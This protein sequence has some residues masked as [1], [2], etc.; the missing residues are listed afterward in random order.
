[1]SNAPPPS[2]TQDLYSTANPLPPEFSRIYNS[3]SLD[4]HPPTF[5]ILQLN[6]H[7]RKNTTLSVVSSESL[8]LAMLLQE[9]WTNLV[10]HLPPT[11]PGWHRV[12]LVDRPGNS[13]ERQQ[14]CIYI[15][16][17]TPTYNFHRLLGSSK[18]LTAVS[19]SICTEHS[20]PQV[21]FLISLYNPPSSFSAIP[22]L[23]SWLGNH[24][25]RQTPTI[26]M[27]D[28]NLHHPRWNPPK[29]HHTHPA[30]KDLIR[31]CGQKGFTLTSPTGIPT[32]QGAR[33]AQTTIDLCWTNVRCRQNVR[34]CTVALNNHA[35]DHQPIHLELSIGGIPKATLST[36]EIDSMV[37]RLTTGIQQ[38]HLKQGAVKWRGSA[39]S[40][41]WWDPSI[42]GPLVADQRLTFLE[43]VKKA[44]KAGNLA[45]SQ[46]GRVVKSTYGLNTK[47]A[48]R[49][50]ISVVYPWVLFA[51]IFWYTQRT[52]K[53]AEEMLEVLYHQA[54]RLITGLFRQTPT[55]YLKK[56]SGLLPFSKI[57]TRQT[58]SYI[59]KA[60]TYPSSHPVSPILKTELTGLKP[61]FPS[62]IHSLISPSTLLQFRD[63]PLETIQLTPAPPWVAPLCQVQNIDT[64]RKEAMELVPHQ[65]QREK[66]RGSLI[67]FTDG[68]WIPEKGA[69]A[70]A[71][72][73]L[74]P[75]CQAVARIQQ[76]NTISNFEIELIGVN[77]AIKAAK[78]VMKNH[79]SDD[80]SAL[81]IFGDNQAALTRSADPRAFT[82]AQHL[83]T[84]NFFSLKHLGL[85]ARLYWTP[86]HEGITA[87]EQADTLAKAD[88]QGV[89]PRSA[90]VEETIHLP[91]SLSTA[92]QKNRLSTGIPE[93]LT[94]KEI[95]R[96]GFKEDTTALLKALDKQEKG[97]ATIIL[98][99]QAD[100]VPLNN[101][102]FK[103]KAVLDPRY[104]E[105]RRILKRKICKLRSGINPDSFR[106]IMDNPKALHEVV[107]FILATKRFPNIQYYNNTSK[108]D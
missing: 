88:A 32:F 2:R 43:Q 10:D 95:K 9:P 99:L 11:H 34:C 21:F 14:C 81:V 76:H 94:S 49:L 4:G 67:F 82:S 19:L 53:A 92:Q 44:K 1:M 26:L 23:Q 65:L 104:R 85:P 15:N 69:G 42:L 102:L 45:F 56:S 35:S 17:S 91:Y 87:N 84:D 68:S 62:H 100:H 8:S 64:P 6:C 30:S 12:T 54:C 29:Y 101:F 70:A 48:R 74:T 106:S 61:T 7:N 27:M 24:Y 97:L 5:T 80:Y 107:S 71:V 46:L 57:H 16:K 18:L 51:S 83:Y 25:S 22:K 40:K 72:A 38:C 77:L 79:P 93:K 55:V 28:S 96:F 78:E 59:L 108:N 50:V 41:G 73:H 66:D 60:L 58:H 89:N 103:I 75:N 63:S 31:L 98:K 86:G 37:E 36:K 52:T 3:H 33:G 105:L 13:S 47:L 90:L 39:R 20:T